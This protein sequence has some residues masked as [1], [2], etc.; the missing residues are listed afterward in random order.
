MAE[1]TDERTETC[2]RLWAQGLSCSQIAGQLG[3]VS[4]NGV[5]GKIHRLGLSGRIKTM[6]SRP[7]AARKPRRV[8][9]LEKIMTIRNG[10]AKLVPIQILEELEAPII[11]PAQRRS[12]LQLT[13]QT[14]H[15][16]IGDP[17]DADFFFCGGVSICDLPYCGFHASLAYQPGSNLRRERR[18]SRG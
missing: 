16:P 1:W 5:I 10:G 2:K 14:C 18:A 7:R 15:F 4:R 11:P 13:E 17:R 9:N 12:I 3:G 6:S 8:I